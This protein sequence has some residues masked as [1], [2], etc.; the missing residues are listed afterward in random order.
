MAELALRGWALLA[1]GSCACSGLWSRAMGQE[2]RRL[3]RWALCREGLWHPV[4]QT[5]AKHLTLVA[6]Q[7]GEL[8][9]PQKELTSQ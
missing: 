1:A 5:P 7:A 2:S 6:D 4:R 3:R 9:P 8:A